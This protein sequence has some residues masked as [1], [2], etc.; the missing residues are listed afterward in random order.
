MTGA[1]ELWETLPGGAL[2]TDL[3]GRITRANAAIAAWSGR[4][5]DELVGSPFVSLLDTGSRLFYETRHL[6]VLRLSG[7]I[8]EVVLTLVGGLPVLVNARVVG[9]ELHILVVDASQRV[10]YE[11]ELLAARRTAEVAASRLQ[12]L[13]AAATTFA[14]SLTAA[15]IAEALVDA[16][17][18][19]FAASAVA[20]H[21]LHRG[22]L[23]LVAGEDP[24]PVEVVE[25]LYASTE[26]VV[27]AELAGLP[28]SL[29]HAMRAAR[30]ESLASVPMLEDGAVVGVLICF[31]GRARARDQAALELQSALARQA[32]NVLGRIQLATELE[33]RAFH[34]ELTGL[35]NRALLNEVLEFEVETVRRGG[36]PLALVFLDLD[37][38]KEINDESG[39]AAGDVVLRAVAE[40]LRGAVRATDT[41]GRFGGDEFVIVLRRTDGAE[42]AE[43]AE[44]AREAIAR[45]I[46]G[47]DHPLQVHASI[48][49]AVHEAASAPITADQLVIIADGAMYASKAAG[50]DTVT[51]VGA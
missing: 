20:V 7:S 6:P 8:A 4:P 19:A 39:H 11:R 44:R 23:E 30:I 29:V 10:G 12:I 34:D 16:C 49:V 47:A 15:A 31:Y 37:G 38:F 41:I 27:V 25:Y 9:E 40:R 32:E 22:R 35:A 3:D 18:E 1:S 28:P 46:E 42:A 13:Q 50:K 36:G 2:T 43:I 24:L 45:P 26:P 21:L 14:A 5:A 48:G 33:Y 51:V 17:R